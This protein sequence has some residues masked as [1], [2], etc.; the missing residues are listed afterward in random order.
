VPL[1]PVIRGK[2][3]KH[4]FF[5]VYSAPHIAIC[6]LWAEFA[7]LT[8]NTICV[9][10]RD[11]DD[12][13][14]RIISMTWFPRIFFWVQKCGSDHTPIPLFAGGAKQFHPAANPGTENTPPNGARCG[15]A[16]LTGLRSVLG[17]FLLATRAVTRDRKYYICLIAEPA[18][19][20]SE[21]VGMFNKISS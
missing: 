17:F 21:F 7:A 19:H 8:G 15:R 10:M 3:V 6:F 4:L 16:F 13:W 11:R 5:M 18:T 1:R 12:S 2:A 9:R 14:E 20:R